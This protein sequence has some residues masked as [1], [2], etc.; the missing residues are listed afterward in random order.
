MRG[1]DEVELESGVAPL[2]PSLL[3]LTVPFSLT[4]LP[5]LSLPFAHV[6]GLPVGVQ[7]VGSRGQDDHLL[8][9]GAW[10]A[11]GRR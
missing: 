1:S 11:S 9:V 2:R 7:V 8:A 5:V 4:G 3:A 6:E 10:L